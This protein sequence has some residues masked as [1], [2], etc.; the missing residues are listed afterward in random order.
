[1]ISYSQDLCTTGMSGAIQTQ[2]FGLSGGKSVRDANC[3][4]IKLSKTLFDM[5]MKVASV[6][7]LCQD[8]RVFEAMEMAGTPCPYM[9]MIGAKA[10]EAWQQNPSSRPESDKKK[11]KPAK[12]EE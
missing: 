8:A 2:I 7:L 9:G 11:K 5:G 6:S 1:M 4:R 3:E 12:K 10:T